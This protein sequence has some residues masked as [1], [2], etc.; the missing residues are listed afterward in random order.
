MTIPADVGIQIE[1]REL[2]H[3][4]DYWEDPETFDEMRFYG[5]NKSRASSPAFQAFGA[6]PR[7]CVGLRFALMEAKLTVARLIHQYK[8]LPGPRT[9]K[10]DSLEIAYKPITMCPKNGVFV[11]AVPLE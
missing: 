2:H 9:E 5:S 7:N 10:F 3:D 11:K 1:V 6:G 8:L 4:P